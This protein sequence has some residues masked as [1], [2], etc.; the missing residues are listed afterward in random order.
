MDRRLTQINANTRNG[1]TK[2]WDAS[3]S[4]SA[5]SN[6]AVKEDEAKRIVRATQTPY[7]QTLF[8]KGEIDSKTISLFIE[9]VRP[10]EVQRTLQTSLHKSADAQ[11]LMGRGKFLS[12]SG[13]YHEDGLLQ[14]VASRAKRCNK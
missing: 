5:R 2:M 4:L 10:N 6:A 8:V 9:A 12:L 3:S 1:M 11:F 14:Q 13:K 7:V